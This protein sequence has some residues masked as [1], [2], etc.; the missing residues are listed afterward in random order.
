MSKFIL[1]LQVSIDGFIA[2][3]DA[4]LSWQIWNWGDVCPW[5]DDLKRTF[6]ATFAGVDTVLLSRKM[7]EGGYL[8]HW[9]GIARRHPRQADFAF[10]HRIVAMD[11][12][13]A[14]RQP[15]PSRWP[16]TDVIG[17]EAADTVRALKQRSRGDIIC[18][19]GVGLGAS[20]VG[21]GL[22]DEYQFYVNP[23]AVAAGATLFGHGPPPRRLRLIGSAPYACGMV[24][25][26]YEPFDRSPGDDR[27]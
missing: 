26:R 25:S 1:Q 3:A 12:V 22:V 8:D 7:I 6:N 20:L 13:V 4:D 2:A 23:T 19:G 21:A 5:D 24:V 9:T 27:S 11:K 16:R 15:V 17:G 18:F 10:A 14:T